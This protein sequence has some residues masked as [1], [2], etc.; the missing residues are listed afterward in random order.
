MNNKTKFLLVIVAVF[1]LAVS[2]QCFA[3]DKT[4]W[5]WPLP[6]E[7]V[8]QKSLDW[9]E[10]KG[11]LPISVGYFADIP[12][13]SAC[14]GIIKEKKLLEKRGLPAKFSSFLSGPPIVEAFLGGQTQVTHYGDFPFWLTVDKGAPVRAY[15]LTAVNHEIAMLV[16]P[17][18]KIKKPEDL[19]Q[20]N[21]TV[22]GTTLGSYAE[23][24][25]TAM[26][27][28]KKLLRDKDFRVAGMSMRDAQLLPKGLDA[29]VLWDPHITFAE[30]KGLGKK[31]DTGY[32]YFFNTGFDF[33]R[34]EIHENAPDVVQALADAAVEAVLYARYDTEGAADFYRK[35][36]RIKAY[37]RKLIVDQTARYL[38]SY[39]PTFRYIHSDFWV[40]EDSRIIKV[41]HEQGRI[42]KAWTEEEMKEIMVPEY[43]A[44][45]FEKLGWKV[46]EKPVFLPENWDGKVAEPPYPDYS[47]PENK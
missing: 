41:L 11:W 20:N 13:Y 2:T 35:D 4:E 6:Y 1:M 23:F 31:I 27:E 14:F 10:S 44:K 26:A 7:Q 22:V 12:G 34:K 43:M 42:N 45:T 29:V 25:L 47:C 36:P 21:I 3:E 17:R 46:P 39:P 30:Q 32:P 9:L 15:A 16:N 18:S 8:S 40:K 37:E 38:T 5:D 33:I 28:N 19:K 24:Y